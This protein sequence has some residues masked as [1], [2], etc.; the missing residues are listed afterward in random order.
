MIYCY[1][2]DGTICESTDGYEQTRP[3]RK[4]I[5]RVNQRYLDGNYIIL[6]TA[7]GS[8]TGE[9]HRRLTE[10]QLAEWGVRYH[11]LHME[12]PYADIYI[13]DR[14]EKPV[15]TMA[16]IQARMDATRLPG[17][18]LL[19]IC[20]K[21]M[22]AHVVDSVSEVLDVV[23]ATTENSPEIIDY[24]KAHELLY[25]VGSEYDVL[26]RYYETAIQYR[27][28][29][30]VRV[31]GDN[32][33]IEPD[34]LRKLVRFYEDGD[35]DWAANCRLKTTFQIGN[36]A[37]IMSFKALETA[38]L[39]AIEPYD[40]E[41]V[42]SFIYNHPDIFKLGVLENDTNQ[43]HLRWTVDTEEDLNRIRTYKESGR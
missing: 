15:K 21:P 24:C 2:I 1:D 16:I 32:P 34:M 43:S 25:Y 31:T 7:R 41:H 14:A 38:W 18:V 13:D 12:K 9:D 30:I 37:E 22:L 17:K 29:V 6:N 35:Y 33:L 10:R 40:R 19:D 8:V 11:E 3:L 4:A 26:D 5:E 20:G 23:I 36:D 39:N 28:D 42:T 27:T